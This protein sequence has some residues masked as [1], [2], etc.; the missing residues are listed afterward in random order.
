MGGG[1]R[2]IVLHNKCEYFRELFRSASPTEHRLEIPDPH[3]V[4]PSVLKFLYTGEITISKETLPDVLTFAEKLQIKS[5]KV[6]P[7]ETRVF[8]LG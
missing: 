8:G 5:L 7:T 4:F 2:S 1:R 6:R 3:G